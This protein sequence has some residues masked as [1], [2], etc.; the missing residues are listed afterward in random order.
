MTLPA[1]APDRF[2][3]LFAVLAWLVPRK[4]ASIAEVAHQF[5]I[6]P[7]DVVSLIETAACCGV[8]PYT[9]DTLLDLYIDEDR[10]EANF[11][12]LLE[13]PRRLTAPEGFA[14]V[15]AARA[16]L[17]VPGA[18]P[19]RSLE[20]ATAKLAEVLGDRGRVAVTMDPVTSLGAVRSALEARRQI[21]VTYY[22]AS[23]DQLSVRKIEPFHLFTADGH[24]YVDAYCHQA[25][26][27]RHFR[28]DR[29]TVVVPTDE[30]F[31][32]AASWA[33]EEKGGSAVTTG[34]TTTGESAEIGNMPEGSAAAFFDDAPDVEIEVP[35]E[36]KRAIDGLPVRSIAMV[37]GGRVRVVLPMGGVPW[38]ERLMLVLGAGASVLSPPELTGL[39]ARAAARV[40]ARY[41]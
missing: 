30:P 9:A 37:P 38:L 21:E 16:I 32:A 15:A 26:A 41:G 34:G 10:I 31:D 4:S 3:L 17:A 22:S 24:W 40:R 18:D 5:T 39:P 8:P 25:D 2:H 14:L 27:V 19:N 12:N 1:S 35:F 7:A 20:R 29:I 28:L 33:I 36:M 13:R 6:D 11:G 23:R